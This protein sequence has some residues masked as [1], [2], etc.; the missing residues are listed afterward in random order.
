MFYFG[1]Q[2]ASGGDPQR[3]AFYSSLWQHQMF[4]FSQRLIT[5]VWGIGLL[6]EA[7]VR[8]A[9]TFVLA[10][11]VFLVVS[12]V[13]VVGTT[14]ALIVWTMSYGRRVAKRGQAAALDRQAAPSAAP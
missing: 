3:A 1:R 7:L 12:Q 5:A 13:I 11:P 9:L 4:R 10:I 2:F 6:A 8:V 14:I